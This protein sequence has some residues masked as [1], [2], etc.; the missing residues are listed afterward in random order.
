MTGRNPLLLDSLSKF[1]DKKFDEAAF[2]NS[3]ELQLV[4]S[5]I[6]CFYEK[7]FHNTRFSGYREE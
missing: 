7:I 1:K 6:D 5:N 4:S 2:L 3:K